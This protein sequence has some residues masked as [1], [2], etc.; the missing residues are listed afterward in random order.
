MNNINDLTDA[1][2]RTLLNN[3]KSIINF[4]NELANNGSATGHKIYAAA[5][6][7]LDIMVFDQTS[8][9][10]VNNLV[11]SDEFYVNGYK[12][13]SA[14]I[15]LIKS[16]NRISAIRELRQAENVDLL[17]AKKTIEEAETRINKQ[18]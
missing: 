14:M 5:R 12:I 2:S 6:D 10:I 9:T 15:S 8:R 7:C 13:T 11:A 3:L 1:E 4:S 16:N 17:T 18:K